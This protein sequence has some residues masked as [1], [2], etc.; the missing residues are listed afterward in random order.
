M[1]SPGSLPQGTVTF[2]FTDIEG[3]TGLLERLGRD[4]YGDLLE[5][6][7]TIIRGAV[8]TTRGGVVDLQGDSIFAAF[9]NATDALGAAVEAE[10][11]LLREEWPQ[12]VR[13]LVRIGVHTGEATLSVNGYVGISV[14][15]GR[16]VCDAAHGGQI[17]ISSATR[18]VIGTEAPAG[19]TFR[20]LG[21]VR[22]AGFD[23]PERLFQVLAAGLPEDAAPPRAQ[24]VW[25]GAGRRPCDVAT[26]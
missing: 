4:A 26:Y 17:V 16:R 12:G 15:R 11:A 14:H 10:R 8:E 24:P 25:R 9:P 20:D 3:S 19:V 6:H 22:L 21:E 13:P 1:G 2:L 5:R 7:R 18:A 23:E